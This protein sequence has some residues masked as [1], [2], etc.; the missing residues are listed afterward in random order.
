MHTFEHISSKICDLRCCI[1]AHGER[2]VDMVSQGK[3]T[4]QLFNELIVVGGYM[5]ALER[6]IEA[7]TTPCP[8]ACAPDDTIYSCLSLSQ[9]SHIF[10]QLTTICGC[11]NCC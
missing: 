6:Y 8:C 3:Y 4:E 1:A 11:Q 5:K 2:Y 7:N 9:A 10:E